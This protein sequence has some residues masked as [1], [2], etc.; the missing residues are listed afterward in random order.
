M[1]IR[2]RFVISRLKFVKHNFRK[3]PGSKVDLKVELST[4]EF[5]KYWDECF[6]STLEKVHLKGF[7]VGQ[8]PKELAS[9]VI[10]NEKVFHEA[11]NNAIRFS[12]SEIIQDNNWTVIDRPKI[13]IEKNLPG[14]EGGLDFKYTADITVFPEIELGDYKTIASNNFQKKEEKEITITSEEVDKALEFLKKS[15]ANLSNF[16]NDEDLKKSIQDGLLMEKKEHEKEKIR[17]KILE[18]IVKDSKIDFPQVMIDRT[19]ERGIND[20]VAKRDVANYLIIY[21]IA[22]IENLNPTEEEINT[23]IQS[24]G[25]QGQKVDNQKLYDYIYGAIQNKKVFDFLEGP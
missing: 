14:G 19:K 11:A 18:E 15:E 17:L 3:L 12:L 20:E 10:D 25:G 6:N 7:R 2:K 22:Q 23:Q 1:Y 21:K 24:Y 16:K 4:E 8:A 5:K 9:Q 13:T